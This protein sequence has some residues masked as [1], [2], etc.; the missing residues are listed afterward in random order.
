VGPKNFGHMLPFGM[1]IHIARTELFVATL[2]IDLA[3][4]ELF[5]VALLLIQ[6][7]LECSK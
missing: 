5:V 7:D 2:L 6:E 4:F 3:G 1:S